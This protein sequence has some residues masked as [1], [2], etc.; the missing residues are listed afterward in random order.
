[1]KT[2]VVANQK[3]GV[4]KTATSI[5]LAF[6]A[7]ERGKRL[8]FID[9]DPQENASDSLES[10]A[11]GLTASALFRADVDLRAAL[12]AALEQEG[13]CIVLIAAD[14]TL[15]NLEKNELGEVGANFKNS[16]KALAELG[17]DLCLID[18]AP[19]IGNAL[20]AA[21]YA[22]DYVLSPIEPERYSIKGIKKMN[23][24]IAN[25]RKAN[26]GLKFLGMV[27]SMVDGRNP[28]HKQHL[29][30]LKAAYPQLMIPAPIGLRGSI[31]DAL[32]MG[33][34]VWQIK[35]TAARVAAKEVRA[36]AQ[37]VYEKMEIAQ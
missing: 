35:K 20:A 16:I 22:S 36:L 37:Y 13:P 18:T 10:F 27:P 28:R 23:A 19:T 4:G 33:V 29:D 1:M 12:G 8:V 17:F 5:H 9:L 14:P 24:A 26:P 32:A 7:L 31:A 21:L 3:G 30:E 34:P 2:A 11:C 25:I 15:A 6:D